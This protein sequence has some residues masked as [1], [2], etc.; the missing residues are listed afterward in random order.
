MSQCLVPNWNL[1]QQ[2]LVE[3]GE[4]GSR[5]SHVHKQQNDPATAHLVPMSD[6][7]VAELT[8]ENGQL[9]MHGLSGLMPT[10]QAKPTWNRTSDT[11]ESII[12]QATRQYQ[13]PKVDFTGQDHPP[14][15]A[16]TSTTI[17]SS[18]GK[19]G[20]STNQV[21]TVP[22]MTRKR[23]RSDSKYCSERNFSPI[24]NVTEECEYPSVCASAS[25]TFCRDND[26]TMM[27]WASLDSGRSLENKTLHEDSVCHCEQES[28]DKHDQDRDAKVEVSRSNSTRSN[29]S[30]AIHNQS[31]R[32][33]RDRINQKMK[34]LQRLVPNSCK[35][36]KA[37]MLDEV[38]EYL[39]QLQAQIQMMSTVR[40]MPQMMM[41][42][43]MQQQLQ[44]AMLAARMGSGLCLGMGMLGI[45]N[46]MRGSTA[47][48]VSLTPLN[49]QPMP[50][51]HPPFVAATPFVVPLPAPLAK[52]DTASATTNASSVRPSDPYHAILAQ[53]INLDLLNNMAAFYR[54]Q[55]SPNNQAKTNPLQLY[56]SQ[57]D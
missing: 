16:S 46:H 26:T 51:A 23:T 21:Q 28:R 43:A 38:I 20:E 27:T 15:I 10:A 52:P 5:S 41:P 22:V 14:T 6:Y 4:E 32:R 42:L 12:H 19:R 2:R 57:G 35:T 53:S 11:L 45:D 13:K 56:R 50:L 9:A 25:A 33:R 8:W 47:S 36:D 49:V 17:A 29:R 34:A 24:V 48:P 39:K 44:M 30:A 37:S 18:G 1:K 7:E 55:M 54:Q 31:E 3:E 40:N